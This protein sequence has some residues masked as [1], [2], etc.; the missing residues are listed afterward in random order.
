MYSIC[1]CSY[2]DEFSVGFSYGDL[3][4]IPFVVASAIKFVLVFIVIKA[5]GN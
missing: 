1:K 4:V 3:H 5:L 2:D